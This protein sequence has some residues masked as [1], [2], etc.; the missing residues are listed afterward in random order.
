MLLY[1]EGFGIVHESGHDNHPALSM[2]Y[3]Y[4]LF[5]SPLLIYTCTNRMNVCIGSGVR[6]FFLVLTLPGSTRIRSALCHHS[7][8]KILTKYILH[9]FLRPGKRVGLLRLM[10]PLPGSEMRWRTSTSS[11]EFT[12]LHSTIFVT[13]CKSQSTVVRQTALTYC[14]IR[15]SSRHLQFICMPHLMR[16][17]I[18]EVQFSVSSRLSWDF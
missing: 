18:S 12:L 5:F 3:I 14:S 2:V 15:R 17:Q 8:P 16:H 10:P 6:N 9:R 4:I 1:I 11:A 7:L 13:F